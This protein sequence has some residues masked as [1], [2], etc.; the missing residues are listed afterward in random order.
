ML[1][2]SITTGSL[3]KR[4]GTEEMFRMLSAAGYSAVDYTI[5]DWKDDPTDA[6]YYDYTPAQMEE[7]YGA[8]RK[9]AEKYGMDVGQ[10]HA[11]FGPY[12][13]TSTPEYLRVAQQSIA[14][15]RAMGCSYLVIHP[16]IMAERK[17]DRLQ[18]ENFDANV[19]FYRKLIP[20]LKE[21]GVSVGLEPMWNSDEKYGKI[22][23]TI[24]SRPEEILQML[25]ALDDPDCFCTCLDVGHVN[26]TGRDTGDTVADAVRK[27][28]KTIR[29]LHIH[30]TNGHED[31]HTA[32]FFG[33]IPWE[34]VMVALKEVGYKGIFN[35]EVG[36]NYVTHFPLAMQQD[37]LTFLCR[38]GQ[39]LTKEL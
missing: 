33:N 10:T 26:I 38:I 15:T 14:A 5:D 18:K 12:T 39:C 30:D 20:T 27:L 16:L 8:I 32:P 11:M 3:E 4:L 7:H 6:F 21:Y 24:F 28:G 13:A 29:I 17:Y 22:C 34:E 2:I 1:K 19:A 9:T 23:P 25:T 35:F 31:N 36:N 37:T